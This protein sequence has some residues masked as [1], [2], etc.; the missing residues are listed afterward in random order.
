[1]GLHRFKPV[2]SGRMGILWTL[3]TIKNSAIIEFGCMGHMHYSSVS[4]KRAGI[5]EGSKL[6]STHIDE[7]DISLGQVKRFEDT[8]DEVVKIENPKVIFLIPSA[9]P[10]MIGSDIFSMTEEIKYKYPEIIFIP[11]GFGGFNINKNKG[12][13]ETLFS[14]CKSIPVKLKKTERP[15]FNIIGSCADIFKFKEDS[16]EIIRI[17]KNAFDIDPLCVLS[18]N[19]SIDDIQKI[20][21]AHLNIV[22]RREGVKSAKYLEKKF[23]TPFIFERPYGIKGTSSWLKK[24]SN[25]C[26]FNL[27][28]DYINLEEDLFK[29]QSFNVIPHFKHIIRDHT[30]ESLLS[31]GGHVD[32]VRGILNFGCNEINLPKGFCWSNCPDFFDDDI[33]F[34]EEE[35]WLNFV[36][37]H[38]KGILMTSG[39]ILK[40]IDKNDELQISNPDTKWRLHGYSVP[41]IGYRGAINLVNIWINEIND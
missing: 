40:W 27:N 13:Q 6:Y 23:G 7:T 8:I 25:L 35:I 19:T 5:Y 11:F 38:D 20:G 17:M 9:I 3:S 29:K 41:F 10:E 16:N 21:A 26:N 22:I 37:K 30:E 34:L 18:S 33:P 28:L 4:L 31:L 1:M 12:V 36:N 2:P 24:I 32:V 39:E 14:L 15:T